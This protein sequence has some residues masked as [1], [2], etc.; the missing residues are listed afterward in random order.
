[1]SVN[2]KAKARAFRALFGLSDPVRMFPYAKISPS[3]ITTDCELTDPTSMPPVMYCAFFQ[4][5][6]GFFQLDSVHLQNSCFFSSAIPISSEILIPLAS[7][8][9]GLF[10]RYDRSPNR[11]AKLR[12]IGNINSAYLQLPF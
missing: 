6:S 8:P 9:L 4:S 7:Y 5:I 2:S 10:R 11:S 1:M 3:A 12:I